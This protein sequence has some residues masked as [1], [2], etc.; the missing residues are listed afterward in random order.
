LK[1]LIE[2]ITEKIKRFQAFSMQRIAGA[3]ELE[4]DSLSY[5][6]VRILFTIILTSV[7][8]GFLSF[9]PLI[10]LVIEQNLWA[11]F[12]F[13]V[14]AWSLGPYLLLARAPSYKIRAGITLFMFYLIGVIVIFTVGVM[15]GG[16][17]W[18]FAFAVLV[19]VLLGSRAAMIALAVNAITLLILSEL[20]HTGYFNQSISIFKS[21]KSMVMAGASFMLL[22]TIAAMSVAV[23]VKGLLS[24]HQKERDLTNTLIKEHSQLIGL[25]NELEQEVLERKQT[26]EA[27][28]DSERRYRLIADNV[29]D[30][31]WTMGMDLKFSYISPSVHSMRGLTVAEAMHQ[32]LDEVMLPD[33]LEKVMTLFTE[34]LTLAESEDPKG[35]QP[36]Y[37]EV[38]QYCKD[39]SKIQTGNMARLLPGPENKPASILGVT[40]DITQQKQAER[41]LRESEEKLARSKKMESLGLLAGGVAHD[42]NNVLSGIVS[43]P[44]LILM[45][46]PD[47]SKLR[48][49]IE[50]IKESG[51]R[52]TAIVQDL[53]TVARGVAITREP[54]NVS[55]LVAEYLRSPEF[56]KLKQYHPN[57]QIKTDLSEDLL[58]VHGSPIHLRKVVMNLVSNAAEAADGDGHIRITTKNQYI[59]RRLKGYED[60]SR[61]EYVVLAVADDGPGISSEDLERIFEPFYT[62]KFMGRSGTGLGLA[63]VW[64][65]ILDHKGYID[66]ISDQNGTK[67]NLY[68]PITRD[69]VSTADSAMLLKDLNGNGETIL[70]VDDVDTQRKISSRMLQTLGYKAEVVASGEQAIDFMKHNKADLVL[71]D[72]IMDPGINGR[73][74]YEGI[75][76]LHPGQKAI[77]VSGFAETEDV[78][79]TQRLG[80]GQYVKKPITLETLGLAVKDELAKGKQ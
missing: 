34:K 30:I 62:K 4:T 50:T 76:K 58:N 74:T 12:I 16:P 2:P 13:D 56:F 19:G 67:F 42:L 48:D 79:A 27:L 57:V 23:L 46:L 72:M 8:V 11:L 78:R 61:G 59:D 44:E 10:P 29:A 36:V 7:V 1:N 39:G 22:N 73:E 18:L 17:A 71:L 68:L 55:D 6:R 21:T 28:R 66:V 35:Y 77:I 5:W 54:L 75:K 63:V 24:A 37:F 25:K 33:S 14:T 43:Y 15:S 20:I 41:V 65:I 26:E 32:N 51:H 38:E 70:V 49:P 80:A 3:S 64:N 52:A 9:I 31:I 45:D 53:L 60:V 40:R 47:D 69:Q